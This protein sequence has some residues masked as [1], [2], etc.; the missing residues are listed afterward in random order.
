MKKEIPLTLKEEQ[1]IRD[2][3]I[4]LCPK[5]LKEFYSYIRTAEEELKDTDKEKSMN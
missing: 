2:V 1:E 5:T 4:V 3:G